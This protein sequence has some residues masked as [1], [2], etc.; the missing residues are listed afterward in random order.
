MIATTETIDD[1][2]PPRLAGARRPD[3]QAEEREDLLSGTTPG[4]GGTV[5]DQRNEPRQRE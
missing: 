5:G 1:P 3:G 4:H 2:A